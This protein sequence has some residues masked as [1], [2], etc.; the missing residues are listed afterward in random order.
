MLSRLRARVGGL[1]LGLWPALSM[2]A[3]AA[4]PAPLVPLLPGLTVT[5]AIAEAG[6][7]YE[8]RK[9]LAARDG[10]GWRL[11]YSA[12]LPE[13][14]KAA[15]NVSSQ[16]LI[17]DEDLRTARRYRN[18]FEDQTEEDYPGTTA[19]GASALVLAELKSAGVAE[20]ALVGDERWLAQALG[21]AGAKQPGALDLAAALMANPNTSFKGSLQR[22]SF[23]K[24]GVLVNGRRQD[25][26][27][28]IASGRFT[29]RS[30][31]VMDVELSLLDDPANPLALEWRIGE[32]RLRVVRIDYPQAG[33][34][35]AQRLK[36]SRR[37]TLPG[38]LFDFGSADLRPESAAALPA[39]VEAIRSAPGKAVRIEG[40]TDSIGD[41]AR[42]QGLSLARAEA[43]RKAVLGL[44]PALA[45]RITASGLGAAAPVATNNTLE[46]RA[47][48]RRV[49]LVLP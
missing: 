7:D 24:L 19:L 44:D 10:E 23:G 3:Q 40:H 45:S 16:R 38:L 26:P 11:D 33:D 8:S 39:I 9:R 20:F 30:G 25:L 46:G 34:T 48:N 21:D 32:A 4:P 47:Q 49:E 35:L 22:Q 17:H 13:P 43:V 18:R 14:G 41:A 5:T 37:I 42:N 1:C 15:R 12:S 36:T 29:A 28:V 6:G 31:A 27:A 2:A